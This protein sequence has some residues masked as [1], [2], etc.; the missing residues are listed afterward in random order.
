M[1]A[2][3]TSVG[4]PSSASRA[5]VL[6][7]TALAVVTSM[8]SVIHMYTWRNSGCIAMRGTPGRPPTS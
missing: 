1:I 8:A 6:M 2:P 4:L 3:S 5:T 7:T